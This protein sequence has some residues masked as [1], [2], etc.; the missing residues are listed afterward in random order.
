VA[1]DGTHVPRS[2]RR[3]RRAAPVALAAAILTLAAAGLL[4]S[5]TDPASRDARAASID[6]NPIGKI[7]HVVIIMQENRSFDSYFG[8]FPGA[9]GIPMKNGEPTVCVP[10]TAKG[11]CVKPYHDARLRHGGGP[12]S[13]SNANADIH[14][15]KMDGFIDQAKDAPNRCHNHDDP[16]CSP[17]SATDVMGYHD[18]REIPNYWAYARNFVLQDRMFQ[19][20]LSWSLPAHLFMVSGWSAVCSKPGDPFSCKNAPRG[21][22]T[23]PEALDSGPP[24]HLAWTDLTYML[25]KAHVSWRYYVFKGGEPDCAEDAAVMCDPA[26]QSAKTPGIWNPLPYFDQVKKNRQRRNVQTIDNFYTAAQDGTLPS[27]S[28]VIPNDRT[29]EHPPSRVNVGQAYVTGLVNSIMKGPD[30]SSTAIF[31]SWDDWG[32][33]YD[34]LKP[35]KVDQNGYGLRVPGL[36]ISPYARQGYI[37]DQVLSH[38]AYLKFIEDVFLGGK[39]LDPATDGRPDP[40]PTVRENLAKLG[41][42]RHDFDFSQLPRPPMLLPEHPPPPPSG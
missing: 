13:V 32:G 2:R 14:G 15:G 16:V 17:A 20:D 41:D 3:L 6:Q 40:R 19:P 27:V 12:H 10:N 22:R 7:K 18:D 34:H 39:R 31:L 8:T 26:K 25:H 42:L 9:R 38:D 36:V 21:P 33:L 37:D 35:P 30:W 5:G 29:G 11:T 24:P 1:P 28:W 4:G 23:G